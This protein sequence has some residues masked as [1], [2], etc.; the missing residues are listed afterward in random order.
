MKKIN[1]NKP[2]SRFPISGFFRNMLAI[3]L[4]E[5]RQVF[6]DPGVLVLFLAASLLYPLLY[7]SIYR[8]EILTNIP[9]AVVDNSHTVRSRDLIR[10]IDATPELKVVYQ[11]NSLKEAKDAFARREIHGV[12][13]IPAD[14]SYKINRMEQVTVSM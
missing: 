2:G 6:H 14:Y 9:V 4:K 5:F 13:Y 7:C 10:R 1:I 3:T 12:V 8:N 11:I